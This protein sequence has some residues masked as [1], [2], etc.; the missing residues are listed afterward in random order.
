MVRMGQGFVTSSLSTFTLRFPNNLPKEL[1]PTAHMNYENR[2]MD[3]EDDLPKYTA[4]SSS[5][6]LNNDGSKYEG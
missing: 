4:F 6:R 5:P 1:L 3:V 2:L